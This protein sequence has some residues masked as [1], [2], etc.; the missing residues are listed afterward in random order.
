MTTP[1]SAVRF[2]C[3]GVMG[4]STMREEHLSVPLGRHLAAS[5]AD[6]LTGGG[7]G[8]MSVVSEAFCRAPH[9]G[10][11]IAILPAATPGSD[12]QTSRE[13]PVAAGH[14]VTPEAPPG[15]PN[16]WAEVVIRTHLGASGGAGESAQSRNS[17]NILSSD[18]VVALPGGPGTLS[19][20]RL[21]IKYG[22]PCFALLGESGSIG[23]LADQAWLGVPVCRSVEEL[24]PLLAGHLPGDAST[25]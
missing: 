3:V 20:V 22:R 15:Y 13:A 12:W 11:S 1:T 23:G 6:I 16:A 24:W 17:I 25:V 14:D 19:E 5:G 10:K 9:A 18:V 7:P 2:P 4:F 8:V 21:A